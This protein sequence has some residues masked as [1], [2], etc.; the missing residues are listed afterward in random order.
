MRKQILKEINK[1]SVFL[2]KDKHDILKFIEDKAEEKGEFMNKAG[3]SIIKAM[4]MFVGELEFS[5][6]PLEGLP[7]FSHLFFMIFI[8]IFVVVL[9]NYLTGIAVGASSP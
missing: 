8:I 5:D 3:S 9:M 6:I 7:Y 4:A 1:S 2:E